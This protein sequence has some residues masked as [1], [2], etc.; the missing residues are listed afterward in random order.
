[1]SSDEKEVEEKMDQTESAATEDDVTMVSE[2]ST[3]KEEDSSKKEEQID[4]SSKAPEP[5]NSEDKSE[6]DP[7]K[8]NSSKP[9]SSSSS[10][11]ITHR[12]ELLKDIES[13][14]EIIF[15][16]LDDEII[17]EINQSESSSMNTQNTSESSCVIT[18][19]EI[20]DTKLDSTVDTEMNSEATPE[21]SGPSKD[22]KSEAVEVESGAKTI[23]EDD[24]PHKKTIE[25]NET[26]NDH[27]MKPD[28]SNS[29]EKE[30]MN[31][32]T[33]IIEDSAKQ[34]NETKASDVL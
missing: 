13:H 20:S 33:A 21:K 12:M 1:M 27:E 5:S 28:E 16:C 34:I 32:V 29:K 25:V 22:K 4:G 11:S 14:I 15:E 17:E 8:V 3:P 7:G 10:S 24:K 9:E 31:N 26:K 6:Q 18:S 30:N 2:N 23:K 19:S